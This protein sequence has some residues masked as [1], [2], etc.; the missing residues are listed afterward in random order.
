[1]LHSAPR[2]VETLSRA[3]TQA[4]DDLAAAVNEISQLRA[5]NGALAA[6]LAA[7]TRGGS[8]GGPGGWEEVARQLE[9]VRGFDVALKA[10]YFPIVCSAE[11]LV[12]IRAAC[13]PLHNG[14]ALL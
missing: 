11:L 7:A 3:V 13:W 14:S 2:L 5:N 8:G 6:Q 4:G 10:L 12:F 9:A 1:M